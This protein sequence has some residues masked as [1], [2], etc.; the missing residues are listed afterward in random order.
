MKTSF[1]FSLTPRSSCSI[2]KQETRNPK[3]E[4][5][6]G[7]AVGGPMLTITGT[8]GHK[9]CQ[10]YSRRD[11]IQAGLLGLGGLSLPWLLEHKARAAASGAGYVKD[12]K[13]VVLIFLGGGAS[14]IETFN[15]NMGAPAPYHSV[16]GELQTSVPGI[17][18][19]GTFPRL[20]QL[21][22][23]MAVVRS[24]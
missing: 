8:S 3:L 13:A 10:G 7:F 23:H 2:T 20:A 9:D 15:P 22:H 21:A 4:T 24:F 19:G 12:N 16:T 18:V 1:G 14:H 6:L 17:T 5:I 11:F